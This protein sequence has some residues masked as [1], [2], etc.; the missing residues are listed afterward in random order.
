MWGEGLAKGGEGKGRF[1]V[2]CGRRR[3]GGA[4]GCEPKSVRRVAAPGAWR[5][6]GSQW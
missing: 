5:F 2:G 4:R 1:C 3:G 6:G